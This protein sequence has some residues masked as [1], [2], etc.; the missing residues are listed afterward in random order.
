[1]LLILKGEG[2]CFTVCVYL[3]K[4]PNSGISVVERKALSMYFICSDRIMSVQQ[5]L[6]NS[7]CMF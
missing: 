3:R 6:L 2:V 1:M 4:L 7:Q 5:L